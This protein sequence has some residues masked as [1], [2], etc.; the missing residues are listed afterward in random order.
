M[1]NNFFENFIVGIRKFQCFDKIKFENF[2]SKISCFPVKNAY[3]EQQ[4]WTAYDDKP[5][6]CACALIFCQFFKFSTGR[7]Q[8]A[9]LK[10]LFMYM[11]VTIPGTPGRK[12]F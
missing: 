10:K 2:F 5:C 1:V 9:T 12:S 8:K 6:S 7:A 3:R 11:R 4:L